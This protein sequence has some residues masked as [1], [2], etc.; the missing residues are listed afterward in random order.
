MYKLVKCTVG[1]LQMA[2]QMFGWVL[3]LCLCPNSWLSNFYL[4]DAYTTSLIAS[5]TPGEEGDLC[6]WSLSSK[7]ARPETE[8]ARLACFKTGTQALCSKPAVAA[9]CDCSPHFSFLLS[10]TPTLPNEPQQ[11]MSLWKCQVAS[12]FAFLE[13]VCLFHHPHPRK[14]LHQEKH[15][16]RRKVWEDGLCMMV[17]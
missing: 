3:T 10:S 17:V 14:N 8:K 4:L 13:T 15:C 11:Q 5:Y 2:G 6:K 7:R 1:F 12:K 16:A 9:C